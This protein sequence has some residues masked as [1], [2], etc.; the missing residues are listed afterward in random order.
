MR[1]NSQT[2]N[3]G[4]YYCAKSRS[5]EQPLN[6]EPK[7]RRVLFLNVKNDVNLTILLIFF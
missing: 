3:N 4:E 5:L 7:Y 2:K 6:I 1:K